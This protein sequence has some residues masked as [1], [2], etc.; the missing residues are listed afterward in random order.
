ME[1]FDDLTFRY[2]TQQDNEFTASSTRDASWQEFEDSVL[3]E[4]RG[5]AK[6]LT[7]IKT[8]ARSRGASLQ[9]LAEFRDLER[10]SSGDFGIP[11]KDTD[12]KGLDEVTKHLFEAIPEPYPHPI[13]YQKVII[14]ETGDAADRDTISA[15]K[16]IKRCMDLRTKYISAHNIISAPKPTMQRTVTDDFSRRAQPEYNVFNR[17]LPPSTS[18]YQTFWR[19]GVFSV[20]QGGTEPIYYAI[21]FEEFFADFNSVR[22]L[23]FLCLILLGSKCNPYG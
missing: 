7:T 1:A 11:V 6:I 20:H 21:P 13:E 23:H 14:T 5:K 4:E 17:P 10:T 15:C 3:A 16:A 12:A 22:V 19:N 2:P 9:N 18:D 8:A